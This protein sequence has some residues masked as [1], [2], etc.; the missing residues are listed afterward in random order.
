MFFGYTYCP[1]ICPLTLALLQEVYGQLA[2]A[3]RAVTQ[4]VLVS[5]D[6]QRDTPARLR[7]YLAYFNP[8]FVGLTGSEA[9]LTEFSRQMGA[10]F[11]KPDTSETYYTV[12]HSAR[13]FLVG[14][15]GATV[16]L[17]SP[18]YTAAGI[19]SDYLAIKASH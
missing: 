9:A 1:D 8:D 11:I 3:D 14:P 2:E 5:V 15:T 10:L 7:E 16:A 13:I 12:D 6:P 18:P 19:L 4:I 17:F